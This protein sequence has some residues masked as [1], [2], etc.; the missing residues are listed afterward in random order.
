MVIFILS[1]FYFQ[2]HLTHDDFVNVFRLT[3]A[4]FQLLPKWKQIELKK[5]Y[6][7]F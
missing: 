6:K 4:E 2:M 5:Q 3:H 1:L 7:L